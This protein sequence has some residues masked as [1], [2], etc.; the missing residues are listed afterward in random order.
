MADISYPRPVNDVMRRIDEANYRTRAIRVETGPASILRST[1]RTFY[2]RPTTLRPYGVWID[3]NR[4][5]TIGGGHTRADAN[6]AAERT[7]QREQDRRLIKSYDSLTVALV[8][9]NLLGRQTGTVTLVRHP[10]TDVGAAPLCPPSV[11]D[12]PVGAVREQPRTNVQHS[13]EHRHVA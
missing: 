13:R 3:I 12:T 8:H 2:I 4:A 1:R 9:V 7:R 5:D 6:A 10:W 11:A